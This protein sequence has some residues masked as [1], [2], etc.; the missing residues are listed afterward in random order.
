MVNFLRT[1]ERAVL[2]REQG[3]GTPGRLLTIVYT[4]CARWLSR[5]GRGRG[6]GGGCCVLAPA[7]RGA[8][9]TLGHVCIEQ[10]LL[11]PLRDDFFLLPKKGKKKH[12]TV[13]HIYSLRK[14]TAETFYSS[15]DADLRIFLPSLSG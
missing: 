2:G 14:H 1:A 7:R 6:G 10:R 9:G 13:L 11:P 4:G 8:A 5:E 3:A 15:P 12:R